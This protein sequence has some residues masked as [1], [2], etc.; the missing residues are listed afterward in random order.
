M[1]AAELANS[2]SQ[3]GQSLTHI[4]ATG[5]HTRTHSH[6]HAHA[7]VDSLVY[8]LAKVSMKSALQP[9]DTFFL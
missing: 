3:P 2:S 8:Y 7:A 4:P 6:T 5:A 1:F 9:A